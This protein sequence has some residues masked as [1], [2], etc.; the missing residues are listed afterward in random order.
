MQAWA[1]GKAQEQARLTRFMHSQAYKNYI[2]TVLTRVN[3]VNGRTY[4]EDPTVFS[5]ELAN[6]PTSTAD[7]TGQTVYLLSHMAFTL[8]C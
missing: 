4:S 1:D 7:Q 3:T 2:H 5:W 8:L 6:E